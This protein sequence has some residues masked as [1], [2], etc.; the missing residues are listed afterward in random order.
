MTAVLEYMKVSAPREP[1]KTPR[2]APLHSYTVC[3]CVSHGDLYNVSLCTMYSITYNYGEN[4]S[5]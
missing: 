5:A 4:V 1:V 2:S 3:H